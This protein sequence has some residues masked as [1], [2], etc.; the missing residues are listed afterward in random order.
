MD[1]TI[2]AIWLTRPNMDLAV[3][4]VYSWALSY[5][6]CGQFSLM[7]ATVW[8]VICHGL[9]TTLGFRYREIASICHNSLR[10]MGAFI[11][12]SH[13]RR[14]TKIPISRNTENIILTG[15][16]RETPRRQDQTHDD[17]IVDRMT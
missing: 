11:I 17:I 14:S 13:N 3:L 16:I 7:P 12:I 4:R 5:L 6:A 9:F 2:K 10:S 1:H 8:L 15:T